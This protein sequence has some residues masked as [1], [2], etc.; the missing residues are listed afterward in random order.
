MNKPSCVMISEIPRASGV[1]AENGWILDPEFLKKLRAV[2]DQRDIDSV[3]LEQ[4]EVVLL[5]LCPPINTQENVNK[6]AE[7]LDKAGEILCRVHPIGEVKH[8]G[9]LEVAAALGEFFPAD[10]DE[11]VTVEWLVSVGWE[12]RFGRSWPEIA[13]PEQ[14][15]WLSWRGAGVWLVGFDIALC[16]AKTRGDVRRLCAALGIELKEPQ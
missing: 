1:D 15:T 5:A 11:P 14:N 10:D 2:C 13:L 8:I 7:E 3:N 4:I 12:R 16:L 9:R 6:Y